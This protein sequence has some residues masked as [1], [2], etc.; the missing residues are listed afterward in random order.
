[1]NSEVNN[2]IKTGSF[3]FELF[4]WTFIILAIFYSLCVF[5]FVATQFKDIVST[6]NVQFPAPTQCLLEYF[7][8]VIASKAIYIPTVF[9]ALI[10]TSFMGVK[11]ASYSLNKCLDTNPDGI[12]DLKF[13]LRFYLI[14]AFILTIIVTVLIKIIFY[15]PMLTLVNASK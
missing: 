1:M 12:G 8:F 6:V 14:A 2:Q 4:L 10:F 11:L 3:K 15:F 9:I 7:D 5:P 13:K